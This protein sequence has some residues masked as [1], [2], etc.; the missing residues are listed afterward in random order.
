MLTTVYEWT[1]KQ[2]ERDAIGDEWREIPDEMEVRYITE[3]WR[4]EK[5]GA[6][7]RDF[8][9][10]IG[11]TFDVEYDSFGDPEYVGSVSP[12]KLHC[13]EETFEEHFIDT[14]GIGDH[15][16]VALVESQYMRYFPVLENTDEH[17]IIQFGEETK[18][19]YDI[20]TGE[21]EAIDEED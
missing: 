14:H 6:T 3:D 2:F 17:V 1:R 18:A 7:E 19:N 15:E 5:C 21:W 9:L 11:A 12:D 16:T 4:D 8:W 10:G 20:V 13:F